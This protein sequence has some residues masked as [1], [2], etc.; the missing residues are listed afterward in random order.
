MGEFQKEVLDI[1][2]GVPRGKVVTY[3]MIAEALGNRRLARAVGLALNRNPTP[4]RI[5]CHRV[6]RSD[7]RV[8]GYSRGVQEK[9]RLLRSEWIVVKHRRINLNDY[10]IGR[11]ARENRKSTS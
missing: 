2:K 11:I 6:V 7:G 4:I 3:G 10:L 1:V 9:V 8:G 5:P